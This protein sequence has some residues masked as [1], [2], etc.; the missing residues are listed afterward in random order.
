MTDTTDSVAKVAELIT[1]FRF[2]MITSKSVEGKLVARPLTVQ[3]VEFDG[4]LWFIVARDSHE[5]AEIAA[6]PVVNVS[7]SSNDTWVSLSGLAEQVDDQAKLKE[8]W[9]PVVA[10]WFTDGP[11]DPNATLVKFVAESAEY[12]DTPGGRVATVISLIKSKVT[13]KAYDGGENEKVEL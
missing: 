10:A 12:W 1:G 6:D 2:A 8:L 7:F 11:D 4:D 5:V 3:E 9:N 13:G